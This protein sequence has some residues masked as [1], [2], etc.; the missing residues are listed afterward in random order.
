M[1]LDKKK[2]LVDGDYFIDLDKVT[3]AVCKLNYVTTI[4]KP[5][6]LKYVESCDIDDINFFYIGEYYLVTK[7][8]IHNNTEHLITNY[9]RRKKSF[10]KKTRTHDSYKISNMNSGLLKLN[11]G[12]YPN[13]LYFPIQHFVSGLYTN[14]LDFIDFEVISDFKIFGRVLSKSI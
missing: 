2:F 10:C 3:K 14:E 11:S 5:S 7:E 1:I 13:E 4:N 8:K 6:V 12:K 9:L